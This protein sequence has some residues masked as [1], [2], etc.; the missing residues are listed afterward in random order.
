MI[1][2]EGEIPSHNTENIMNRKLRRM[3]G[4]PS[5]HK[6]CISPRNPIYRELRM[7]KENRVL[8]QNNLSRL[9]RSILDENLLEL[10]PILVYEKDGILYIADGQ[11]RYKIA[12]EEHLDYYIEVHE[13]EITPETIAKLNTNQRNWTVMD[14]AHSW[15]TS[16]GTKKVYS[17]Y[18]EYYEDHNITHS[19]LISLFNGG[20]QRGIGMKEFKEGKL[21][22]N[23]L[24]KEYVEDALYKMKQLEFAAFNPSMDKVTLRRQTFQVGMLIAL[25]TPKFRFNRFIKNLYDVKHRFNKYHRVVDIKK[26]IFRIESTK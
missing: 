5:S 7:V 25:K 11:H 24:I 20:T 13:G 26:E 14:F 9:R 1:R 16:A 8:S 15:A 22:W 4:D 2:C 21:K 17:K 12:V 6:Y 18:L 23:P 19:M 10:R 3:L